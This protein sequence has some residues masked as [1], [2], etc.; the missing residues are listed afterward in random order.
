M[1]IGLYDAD[2][3]TYGQ[4]PFN[5]E[6][7]KLAAYYKKKKEITIFS[8]ELNPERYTKFFYRK[9]YYD[10]TYPIKLANKGNV[11]LDGYAFHP[12][13]YFPM[14][15]EVELT[16]PD[17][18]IYLKYEKFFVNKKTKKNIFNSMYNATHLRLSVDGARPMKN[19][20]HQILDSKIKALFFHDL[21]LDKVNKS[22]EIIKDLKKNE[23][24]K[25]P[26][27]I[28]SKYPIH[29]YSKEDLFNWLSF[30]TMDNY[31]QIHHFG[32]LD[33]K[34]FV[35]GLGG[36]RSKNT[37]VQF[38]YIPFSG[39]VIYDNFMKEKGHLLFLQLNYM[40]GIKHP[41]K[42][43]QGL[44]FEDSRWDKVI[45]FINGYLTSSMGFERGG[46]P[47]KS[48]TPLAYARLLKKYQGK[49]DRFLKEYLSTDEL[50]EIFYFVQKENYELFKLFY[51]C[52]YS[53][54]EG[55]ELIPCVE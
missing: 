47:Y 37:L 45:R 8:T 10:G 36:A 1:S 42:L 20:E 46:A 17:K 5:L 7:M 33:D 50:R 3:R 25:K 22:F 23:N 49:K 40:R 21:H 31:Y 27:R 52:G 32:F 28:G 44:F 48:F 51:E 24:P 35:N 6:L 41:I 39:E 34:T 26:I 43:S 11:V 14:E 29:T 12:E 16:P 9:D 2:M 19:F 38:T 4:V 30:E 13:I 54:Y 18:T 53:R 55:G 15:M